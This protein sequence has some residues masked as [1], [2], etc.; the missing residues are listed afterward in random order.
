M[1]RLIVQLLFWLPISD[2]EK[3][4]ATPELCQELRSFLLEKRMLYPSEEVKL[5]RFWHLVI[6]RKTLPTL[7]DADWFPQN[8]DWIHQCR[9]FNFGYQTCLGRKL[10]FSM[11][12]RKEQIQAALEEA[13]DLGRIYDAAYE[14][15][16]P[17]N[18]DR[19][20][21]GLYELRQLIGDEMYFSGHLPDCVPLHR[22]ELDLNSR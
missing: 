5:D 18:S 3:F 6:S 17:W 12:D 1:N 21:T 19:A 10:K 7:A 22:F 16:F 2:M 9:G 20:L 13:R 8:T 15:K 4:P 14:A 11:G